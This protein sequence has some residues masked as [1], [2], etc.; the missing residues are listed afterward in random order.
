MQPTPPFWFLQRQGKL[1]AAGEN[2]YRATAPNLG[3]A[4]LG[5]RR[6]ENGRW[7]AFLRAT[8]DGNDLASTAAEFDAPQYAW[9]AAFELHRNTL[10][11]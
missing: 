8:A 5:I 11:V 6:S 3:E 4:Y 10:V 7:S 2:V 1:E 9:D